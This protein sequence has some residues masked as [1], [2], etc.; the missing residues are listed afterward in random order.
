MSLCPEDVH[1]PQTIKMQFTP[2]HEH[3]DII[4]RRKAKTT[5]TE[6]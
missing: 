1:N 6:I 2:R 3:K 4:Y 5:D